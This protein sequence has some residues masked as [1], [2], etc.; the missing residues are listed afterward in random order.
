MKR[1]WKA[2]PPHATCQNASSLSDPVPL[3]VCG[4]A[5]L[6]SRTWPARVIDNEGDEFHRQG[7][8]VY[9]MVLNTGELGEQTY[10]LDGIGEYSVIE[11]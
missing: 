4:E 8:G 1:Q 3:W 7:D 10:T 2:Q 11:E 5:C 6:T 9:R